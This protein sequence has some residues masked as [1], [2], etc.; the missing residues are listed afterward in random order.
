MVVWFSSLST[1]FHNNGYGYT[2][3]N[4][5]IAYRDFDDMGIDGD[6]RDEWKWK[7][8]VMESEALK[9]LNKPAA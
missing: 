6:K 5:V 3:F 2:G 8:K 7:M 9:H 1:Q 4:Y